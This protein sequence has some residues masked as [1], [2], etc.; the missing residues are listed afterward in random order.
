MPG[1]RSYS[2]VVPMEFP[3][4][5]AVDAIEEIGSSEAYEKSLELSRSGLLVGPSSGMALVGLLKHLK[6]LKDG[7]EL[8]SLRNEETGEIPCK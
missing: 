2:L 6:K 8:D 5:D 3:W 7:G 1:P 4:R